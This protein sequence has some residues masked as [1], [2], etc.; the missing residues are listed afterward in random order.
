M[1]NKSSLRKQALALRKGLSPDALQSRNTTIQREAI[2]L[3]KRALA[4]SRP[5]SIIHCFIPIVKRNEPDVLTALMQFAEK[6]S[7]IQIASPIANPQ[8][9]SMQQYLWQNEEQLVLGAY[10]I[11][12][13]NPTLC[14]MVAPERT[15]I[16]FIPALLTNL[17]GHRIGYGAGYYDRFLPKLPSHCLKIAVGLLPLSHT[18]WEADPLDVKTDAWIGPEGLVSFTA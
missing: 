16:I 10:G 17:E 1:I 9:Y 2:A 15:D 12:E 14:Q 8:D 4:S 5:P 7:G 3:V 13:P 11:R 6:A 18:A